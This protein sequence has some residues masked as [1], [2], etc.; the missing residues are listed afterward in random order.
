MR[1]PKKI[2][3]CENHIWGLGS[4]TSSAVVEKCAVCGASRGRPATKREQSDFRR[5]WKRMQKRV[6]QIH[7]IYHD[8]EL[9]FHSPGGWIAQGGRLMQL[10]ER[11]AKHKPTVTNC[12]VDDSCHAGSDLY[13]IPHECP[14]EYW[15]TTVLY[16][17]QCT[18]EKPVEFF[19]Y[20]CDLNNLLAKLQRVR[21]KANCI[22][23]RRG[24]EKGR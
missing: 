2:A 12:R 20:P 24:D 13:L 15:G 23:K 3:P 4:H 16:I 8:F 9:R 7:H 1:K 10:V 22:N 19:L 11:W 17:P 5:E 6:A 18:G 21:D 14:G